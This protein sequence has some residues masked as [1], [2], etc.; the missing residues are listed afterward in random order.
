M[1]LKEQKDGE[2]RL[3]K[4][5]LTEI[6]I[7]IGGILDTSMHVSNRAMAQYGLLF[8][9]LFVLGPSIQYQDGF[10]GA[11]RSPKVMKYDM[12]RSSLSQLS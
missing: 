11:A 5:W 10:M 9:E 4:V 8:E 2:A 1:G 3:G 12:A 7:S 6:S